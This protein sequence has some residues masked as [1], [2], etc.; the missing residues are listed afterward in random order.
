MSFSRVVSMPRA[1]APSSSSLMARRGAELRATN[2]P[3][4]GDDQQRADQE[5][6]VGIGAVDLRGQDDPARSAGERRRDRDDLA[7]R[8]E[9][10]QHRDREVDAAQAQQRIADDP[11]EQ[12]AR[13]GG[14]RQGRGE[15][16]V[17][18]GDEDGGDVAADAEEDAVAKVDVAGEA[19]D[20]VPARRNDHPHED[21]A[22]GQHDAVVDVRVRHREQAGDAGGEQGPAAESG[23]RAA[24]A[25][26]A[27]RRGARCG[28]RIA[29]AYA[30]PRRVTPRARIART[31]TTSA[32]AEAFPGSCRCW[33]RSRRAPPR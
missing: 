11:G 14:E 8:Q 32:N 10:A 19:G 1:S 29:H 27:A 30:A 17:G 21:R 33:E 12:R 16:K 20:Q 23:Q 13:H 26:G 18:P 22:E 2:E 31:T 28:C 24:L 6:V 7:N 9:R 15:R 5:E 4:Q 3:G 25:R